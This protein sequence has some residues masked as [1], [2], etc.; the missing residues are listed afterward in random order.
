MITLKLKD[1]SQIKTGKLNSNAAIVDG[2]YPF[3]TCDPETSRIDYYSFDEEAI[4]LAG[5]N[6]N[7]RFNIKYYCGKF[8]AYQRTYII[9]SSRTE[10]S[11]KYLYYYL[12]TKLS[13]F[14]SISTGSAT[15]FLTK[16]ILDN[17]EIPILSFEEQRH[18]VDTKC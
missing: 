12:S 7:G 14:T 13:H 17:I 11:T 1:C 4:L 9:N 2:A 8:N 6:A 18:I 16:A 3:F 5:N 10:L 15:K